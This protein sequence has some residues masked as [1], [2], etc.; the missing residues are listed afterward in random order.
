LFRLNFAVIALIPKT[1]NADDM[2]SFRPI[3]LL[4]CNFKTFSKV[5]TSRLEN[6]YLRIIAKE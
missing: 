3:G 2:R 4:N 1:E 5:L 6:V